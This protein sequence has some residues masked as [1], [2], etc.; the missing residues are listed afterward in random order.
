MVGKKAVWMVVEWAPQKAAVMVAMMV[1]S[2]VAWKD[3]P[4][5]VIEV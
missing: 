3:M 4:L 1:A 2:M 5:E